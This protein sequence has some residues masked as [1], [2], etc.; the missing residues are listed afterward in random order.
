MRRVGLALALSCFAAVVFTAG[1]ASA[2]DRIVR[3]PSTTGEARAYLS[4][5]LEEGVH[6]A[7]IVLHDRSGLGD[8]TKQQAQRFAAMGYVTLALDLYRGKTA[9]SESSAAEMMRSLPL[10]RV[11][12]DLGAAFTFLAERSDV[13]PARIGVIGWCMGGGYALTLASF[14]PRIAAVVVNYGPLVTDAAIWDRLTGPVLANFA[15]GTRG[16]NMEAIEAFQAAMNE[17]GREVDVK[18]YD[19]D[20]H[21]FMNP[22]ADEEFDEAASTDAWERISRFFDAKLRA[23]IPNS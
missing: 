20:T 18:V 12:A 23:K 13:D 15:R 1:S 19:V 7:V 3:F 2:S 16:V 6:P 11:H 9:T 4:L 17:R 5:P 8:W 21:A 10:H 22:R 14:E